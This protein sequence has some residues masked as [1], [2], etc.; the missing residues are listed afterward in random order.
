MTG[1][2][3]GGP[4][5]AG[6]GLLFSFLA[7]RQKVYDYAGI[8]SSANHP[9]VT[10]CLSLGM[11]V[12]LVFACKDET[13]TGKE[14]PELFIQFNSLGNTVV[15]LARDENAAKYA[16]RVARITDGERHNGEGALAA[17]PGASPISPHPCFPACFSV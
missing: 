14:M 2:E 7:C 1:K 16:R 12:Q 3:G 8:G 15:M 13:R 10:A 11:P 17:S 4:K 5:A 6:F 9:A